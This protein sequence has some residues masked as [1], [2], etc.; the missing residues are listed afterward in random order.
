MTQPDV[1][2]VR[3]EVDEL[4]VDRFR[5][6]VEGASHQ[7]ERD[8]TVVLSEVEFFPSVAIGVLATALKG[9]ARNG[10]DFTIVA[11]EESVVGRVLTISGMPFEDRV[12]GTG[13]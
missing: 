13:A 9:A 8:L 7:H 12:P 1:L 3:G 11:D 4:S 10:V 5:S 6:D 2:T